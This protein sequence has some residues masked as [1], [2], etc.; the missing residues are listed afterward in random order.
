[1]KDEVNAIT[2]HA[3]SEAMNHVPKPGK[4]HDRMPS[5]A[6]PKRSAKGAHKAM[7]RTFPRFSRNGLRPVFTFSPR[8]LSFG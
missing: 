2:P 1:M 6:E 3:V 4:V 8:W 5:R 7:N